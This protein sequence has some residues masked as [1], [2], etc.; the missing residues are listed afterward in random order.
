M[1][2]EE[3]PPPVEE[4]VDLRKPPTPGVVKKCLKNAGQIYYGDCIYDYDDVLIRHGPGRQVNT[5]QTVNGKSVILGVYEGY[6]QNDHMT[7]GGV[8][9]WSDG[10][11]YE[12]NFV[13]GEMH[14]YGKFTW[15]EGS[16]YDGTWN[17]NEMSGQGRF[18]SGFDGDFQQGAFHRNCFRQ[19]DGRWVDVHRTREQHRAGRLKITEVDPR[20][21]PVMRCPPEQEAVL[22]RCQDAIQQNL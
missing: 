14:G 16:V 6:W 9:R 12:G 13:N 8:Y 10:S 19:Y 5:A 15:S 2:K 7:G 17:R 1:K 20:T 21:V 4:P 18:D 11:C 22:A 3:E